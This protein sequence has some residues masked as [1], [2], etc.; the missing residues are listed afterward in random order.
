MIGTS[1]V[2]APGHFVSTIGRHHGGCR[3]GLFTRT[4]GRAIVRVEHHGRNVQGIGHGSY[5]VDRRRS[6]AVPII[7]DGD[8][9][10]PL[11]SSAGQS[12]GNVFR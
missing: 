8:D 10:Q 4:I 9:D 1:S 11:L 6:S 3:H 7:Q 2:G 5:Y 12:D